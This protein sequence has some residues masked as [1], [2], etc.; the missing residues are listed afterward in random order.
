MSQGT[1][2]NV[3]I[4]AGPDEHD[5]TRTHHPTHYLPDRTLLMQRFPERV[6]S[7]CLVDPVCFGVFMPNLLG[8][9]VYRSVIEDR[10]R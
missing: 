2:L 8:N 1:M 4:R 9:F 7:A 10:V 5:G 3:L 6:H